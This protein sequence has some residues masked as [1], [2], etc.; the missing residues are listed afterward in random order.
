MRV[1]LAESFGIYRKEKEQ[2]YEP[3]VDI[4]MQTA[5]ACLI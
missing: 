1:E 4:L 5:E 2:Q 3:D